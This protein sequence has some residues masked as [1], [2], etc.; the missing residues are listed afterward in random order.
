MYCSIHVKD[1]FDMA[2]KSQ[3]IV[4]LKYKVDEIMFH[5][6]CILVDFDEKKDKD[7]LQKKLNLYLWDL[8]E[9]SKGNIIRLDSSD[10]HDFIVT[11]EKYY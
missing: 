6:K 8:T 10:I 3:N 4:C 5:K 2:K 9:E 11:N 1:V 7:T